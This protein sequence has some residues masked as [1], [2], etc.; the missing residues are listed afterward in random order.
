MAFIDS[1]R[2]QMKALVEILLG[3]GLD[4]D[5]DTDRRVVSPVEQVLRDG[6]AA[7]EFRDFDPVVMATVVQRAVDGLP[8]L[9]DSIPDLDCAHYARELVALFEL[10][11]TRSAP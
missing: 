3:G 11:T 7:G 4:Y 1:H 5:A 6:Q 2:P 8:F 10:G 9:L